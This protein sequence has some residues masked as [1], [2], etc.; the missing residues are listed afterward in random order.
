MQPILRSLGKTNRLAELKNKFFELTMEAGDYEMAIAGFEAS[1]EIVNNETRLYLEATA[2]LAIAHLRNSDIS[3]AKP[4]IQKVL[5]NDRYIKTEST[6]LLF[7]KEII[8]RFDE[9]VALASLKT[10]TAKMIDKGEVE[11]EVLRASAL[12]DEQLYAMIGKMVP[13]ITK[14]VLLEVET[15]AKNLLPYQERKL[16]APP[17]DIV[18]DEIA[19]ETVFRSFKRVL[20]DAVC[21]KENE[22]YKMLFTNGLNIAANRTLL[23]GAITTALA[24]FG[25]GITPV[26][27]FA[28]TIIVRLGLDVYCRRHKPAGI[29]ELRRKSK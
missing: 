28:A 23:V 17:E 21:D 18:R 22:V 29:T 24:G 11:Q 4:Y 15:F 12:T 3:K 2:L 14:Q 9:E 8:A 13:Q 5:K 10:P 1:R 16:L 25:I 19:G 6:R 7:N 20:Y 26:I 27:V